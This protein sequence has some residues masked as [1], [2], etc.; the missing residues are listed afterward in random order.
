MFLES[1]DG[2]IQL[3]QR[4]DEGR[5]LSLIEVEALSRACRLRLDQYRVQLYKSCTPQRSI[6]KRLESHRRRTPI[7]AQRGVKPQVFGTR[8]Q[9]IRDYLEW[10]VTFHASGSKISASLRQEL[11]TASEVTLNAINARIP[12]S[13]FGL[14]GAER[15]GLGDESVALF[16]ALTD[17]EYPENPWSD[18]L[19][20]QRNAL[21]LRWLHF[22]GIRRGE[23]LNVRISDIDFARESV[24]IVRRAD[25]KADPRPLQP[26]VKTRERRLPLK[27]PLLDQTRDYI[28]ESRRRIRAAR[29][30]DYLFVS[31]SGAPL[32]IASFAKLFNVLRERHLV[33]PRDFTGHVLRHTWN[34]RYSEE[35]DV[36]NVPEDI[37]KKTRAYLMGWSPTS[38][39]AVTYTRRHIRKKA[40]QA[41]VRLQQRLTKGHLNK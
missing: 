26:C 34:E 20:R 13:R 27:P 41:S 18:A 4:F 3:T 8:L 40:Q 37:E 19:V 29:K 10:L 31:E 28:L 38:E 5:L 33:L 23:L 1:Q 22:L 17:P 12:Q 39:M 15:E 11:L 30:H 35:M 6:S 2:G 16:L 36:H 7:D 24:D 21:I 32:S 25:E 14:T 9:I